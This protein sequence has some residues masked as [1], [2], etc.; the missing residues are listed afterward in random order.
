LRGCRR[1]RQIR[2]GILLKKV[3]SQLF[4]INIHILANIY[5]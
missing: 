1:S 2:D 5:I 3:L 4:Q